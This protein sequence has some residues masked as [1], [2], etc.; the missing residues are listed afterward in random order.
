[1]KMSNEKILETFPKRYVTTSGLIFDK[2]PM[3]SQMTISLIGKNI[4]KR[5]L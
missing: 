4:L 1:M 2:T 3:L 5:F